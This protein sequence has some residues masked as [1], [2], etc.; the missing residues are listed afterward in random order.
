MEVAAAGRVVAGPAGG[1]GSV[2]MPIRVAVLNKEGEPIYSQ[3]TK[4]NAELPSGT[5][6]TQFLFTKPGVTIPL[7]QATTARV[8]VGFDEGPYK[9]P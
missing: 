7:D 1:P 2:T 8:F 9:T 4:Y 6:T 3:L 5:A